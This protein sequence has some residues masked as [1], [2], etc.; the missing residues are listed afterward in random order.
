[1]KNE[2]AIILA[3]S[4]GEGIG[5]LLLELGA[6]ALIS[7]TDT[8]RLIA[9][10]FDA[11]IMRCGESRVIILPNGESAYAEAKL[12]GAPNPSVSVLPCKSF[13]E[14]YAALA[15]MPFGEIADV[16]YAAAISA[17]SAVT[18][19]DIRHESCD[20]FDK[21]SATSRGVRYSH[22]GSAEAA[23]LESVEKLL[24]PAHRIIT[25]IVGSG[26]TNARRVFVTERLG[27]LYP[28]VQIIVYIGGQTEAEY[29]IALR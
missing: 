8:E 24:Q 4:T 20:L 27:E 29:Y 23:L 25:L 9:D 14:G 11:A 6:D 13:A 17:I 19:I 28:D 22:A 2:T 26:V 18:S 1:M 16:Q 3:T 21:F 7:V 10:D 5:E 15:A 12:A